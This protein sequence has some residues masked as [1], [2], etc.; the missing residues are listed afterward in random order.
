MPWSHSREEGKGIYLSVFSSSPIF[1]W[2]VFIPP[3]FLY[4]ALL[5]YSIWLPR[6]QLGTRSYTLQGG[7]LSKFVRE[8]SSAGTGHQPRQRARGRGGR[9]GYASCCPVLLESH[10][11]SASH[12]SE[13]TRNHTVRTRVNQHFPT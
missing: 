6:G 8:D 9:E 13:S 12:N 3:G 1:H 5:S 4:L 10:I 2:S 7:D 11:R